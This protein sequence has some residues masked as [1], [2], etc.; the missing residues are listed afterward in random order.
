M[1]SIRS[2]IIR[3]LLSGNLVRV[4]SQST[5]SE[6]DFTNS[7]QNSDDPGQLKASPQGVESPA[8]ESST[9]A[10]D[11]DN[12]APVFIPNLDLPAQIFNGIKN[13]VFP[14]QQPQNPKENSPPS[15]QPEKVPVQPPAGKPAVE[16]DCDSDPTKKCQ[17]AIR[18]NIFA[19]SCSAGPVNDRI[20][21]K[22]RQ[23]TWNPNDV[24]ISVLHGCG[25]LFWVARLSLPQA[26]E[27][28]KWPG[29]SG[30][31]PDRK[32][33]FDLAQGK[34]TT[35]VDQPIP[36]TSRHLLRKRD[37]LEVRVN[38]EMDLGHLSTPKHMTVSTLYTRYS[39]AGKGTKVYILGSGVNKN[40]FEISR[41]PTEEDPRTS[42]ISGWL[43]SI[44]T[45][46]TETN[47][48]NDEEFD[49]FKTN[50]D[51]T[52]CLVSKIAGERYGVASRAKVVI[53]K[54]TAFMSSALYGLVEILN[55]LQKD[56]EPEGHTVVTIPYDW[57][58]V[59][60]LN[61]DQRQLRSLIGRLVRDYQVVVVCSAGHSE[62]EEFQQIRGVPALFSLEEVPIITVSSIDQ[63]LQTKP[64]WAAHGSAVTVAAAG[65]VRCATNS[66]GMSTMLVS[67]TAAS[68]AIVSG[69]M[70]SFLSDESIG[71]QIRS[72]P[73]R[74]A[75]KAKE[76]LLEYAYVRDGG[77]EL[78][79][80][81]GLSYQDGSLSDLQ[82]DL[83]DFR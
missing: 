6:F 62:S 22:L 54:T 47:D 10:L 12:P 73:S 32:G 3:A 31:V 83:D 23:I 82:D 38:P 27:V 24:Y 21:A 61:D 79:A 25:A 80:W 67:G 60:E 74:I 33:N 55:D 44:G 45:A 8:S 20:T 11:F 70:L 75:S 28:R 81:N 14:P 34:L 63:T 50:L 39:D 52:P 72:T 76:V 57:K 71:P 49:G 69:L 1:T 2:F 51:F 18:M 9:I 65:Y 64:I 35:K 15:T 40:N 48:P 30:V 41:T 66:D 5:N 7:P 58:L 19:S 36:P 68:T 42:I 4:F 53:V 43:Y 77:Q 17:K 29:V 78:T 16:L 46:Q 59:V 56:P 26:V 13:F 37:E